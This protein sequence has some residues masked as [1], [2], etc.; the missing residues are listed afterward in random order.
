MKNLLSIYYWNYASRDFSLVEDLLLTLEFEHDFK[1]EKFSSYANSMCKKYNDNLMKQLDFQLAI[2]K[3]S[4]VDIIEF[5][6]S[7]AKE[8]YKLIVDGVF[9]QVKDE[10][11]YVIMMA[12]KDSRFKSFKDGDYLDLLLTLSEAYKSYGECCSE[13]FK[14]KDEALEL[15]NSHDGFAD[16]KEFQYKMYCE[17]FE[18][19]SMTKDEFFESRPCYDM[20]D[21]KFVASDGASVE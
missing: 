4:I 1:D 11:D 14:I 3:T 17:D 19:M 15:L 9:S 10:K 13:Y 8:D 6:D 18:D 16:I 7:H 21:L 2:L 5:I 12:D 20:N